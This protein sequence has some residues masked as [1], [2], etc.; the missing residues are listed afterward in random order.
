MAVAV[1]NKKQ[2]TGLAGSGSLAFPAATAGNRLIAFVNQG[3]SV[4]ELKGKDSKGGEAGWKTN[5]THSVFNTTTASL[6]L[7]EKVAE[8]GE[9]EINPVPGSGGTINGIAYFEV[10]G[11]SETVDVIVHVDNGAAGT[12]LS[13]GA[14]TT[15]DA[16]DL[17]L[18][19]VGVTGASEKVNAW[20]GTGPMTNVETT[21]TRCIGGSYIPGTTILGS[22]TA[23]WTKSLKGG[24]VVVALKP[25]SGETKT[26]TAAVHGAGASTISALKV[27][28]PAAPVHGAGN[29]QASSQ[30]IATPT[31]LVHGAGNTTA[32]VSLISS[33]SALVHGAGQATATLGAE[34]KIVTASVHG[35]GR[36]TAAVIRVALAS[37]KVTGAGAANVTS[38]KISLATARVTGAGRASASVSKIARAVANVTGAGN[39]VVTLTTAASSTRVR[40]TFSSYPAAILTI[41]DRRAARISIGTHRAGRITFLEGAEP[42]AGLYPGDA[43]FPSD[44]LFPH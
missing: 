16:G 2:T 41:T 23:N 27:A 18:A 14:V 42:K 6:W 44:A 7:I 11:T 37:A 13:S 1:V 20:T 30:K 15:T 10:S 8:G 24:M 34:V 17:I 25:A 38:R 31:A 22:F 5:A 3:G 43:L 4:L 32:N 21:S 35:A 12:S 26:V 40:L 39:V 33:V 29:P 9:T 36:A 28:T 19:G